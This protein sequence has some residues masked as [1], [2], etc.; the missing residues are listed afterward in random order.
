MK[1]FKRKK[2]RK[3]IKLLKLIKNQT[4]T[5]REILRMFLKKTQE[6]RRFKFRL[7][8][9]WRQFLNLSLLRMIAAR[10]LNMF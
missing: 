7:K 4:S 5:E 8:K 9:R 10:I 6:K 1:K 2:M 3:C